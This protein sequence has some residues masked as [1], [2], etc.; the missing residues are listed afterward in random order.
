MRRIKAWMIVVWS[1]L[2]ASGIALGLIGSLTKLPTGLFWG[3]ASI[4]WAGVITWLLIALLTGKKKKKNGRSVMVGNQSFNRIMRETE[5]A[6]ARYTDAVNRRGILK[7]SALYERPWFLLCGSTK[8]GK[9][10][11]LNGSGL[12][13]PLRYP[14]E[15][16]GLLVEG[17]N[18][19]MWYFA[20]EAVWID[21]P[22]EL[23][24]ESGR[25]DWQ[26]LIGA[27]QRVRPGNPAD[28]VAMVVNTNEVLNTDDQGIKELAKKLRSRIDELISLWGIEFPVYLLFNRTDEVPGFNEYFADQIDRGNEQIF[29]ATLPAKMLSVMPRMA[30][31]EEFNLLCKSLTDLRLD[32]L[33]KER[34]EARKRMICRFV[35]HFEGI[36]Q[37]LGALV[38]ELFKP[39]N[40]EGKP[41]FRGFYFTS[42]T[43][44]KAG[45]GSETAAPA[46]SDMSMTLIN[47]P[48]NPNRAFAP[49]AKK[50]PTSVGGSSKKTVR[51][52]FVLPLFREIMVKDKT[53]VTSTQ[54]RTRREMIRHYT[55]IGSIVG[56]ALLL[57][58]LVGH[59]YLRTARFM[60]EVSATLKR[61]PTEDA[62]LMEQYKAL[63]I[64]HS[65]MEKLQRYEDRG[66]PLTMGVGFYRG[67]TVLQELKKSYFYRLRR[68]M[69]VPAVKYLEY[70]LR[71]RTSAF[72][73]LAG[74]DY[75]NLYRSLKAYLSI[76]EGGPREARDLDTTFMREMLLNAI[77]QSIVATVKNN[78]LP[79]QVE[80]IL[81]D[82][83][84]LYLSYLCRKEYP[85]I[86]ENQ[87]LVESARKR[88]SRLPSAGALYDAVI[89]RLSTEA[90]SFTL[91]DILKRDGEGILLS[92]ATI[93]ALFTQEGWENYISDAINEAARNPFKVDWVIGVAQDALPQSAFDSKGLREDMVAAYLTDFKS[94]WLEFLGSVSVAP[95]G[96]LQR[97]SRLIGKLAGDG[98]EITTLLE[99]VAEY[100][101]LRQESEAEAAGSK[102]LEAASKFKKTKKNANKLKKLKSKTGFTLPG[103]SPFDTHNAFFDHLRS[104][105]RSSGSALGGFEGYKDKAM[106]LA[107]KCGTIDAQGESKAITIFNGKDDDPLLSGWNFTQKT[108]NSMPEEL[109][110][111]LRNILLQP[112]E[113]TGNAA[114]IVLTRTLNQKWQEEIIKP[115]TSRFSGRYPFSSRG[116]EASFND[117]MDFFR[118]VNG[119]FWGFYERVLS[120]FI[121]KDGNR[122]MV[123]QLGSLKLQFNPKLSQSL[124]TA[125]RVRDIF[126]K[127][128]GTQ[129]ALDITIIPSAGNKN[130]ARLIIGTQDLELKPGG[131]SVHLKWPLE[132]NAGTTL[133]VIVSSNFSQEITKSGAWGFMKL[134]EMARC[135]KM[136]KSSFSAK[137]QVN[138]QNQY[139]VFIEA[140]VQVAGSDHPFSDKIFQTFDCPTDLLLKPVEDLSGN[141]V[142]TSL[143]GD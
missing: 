26:A 115:F 58:G 21:T 138:V 105:I 55:I 86:Q 143:E 16:D 72:G 13:F 5:E 95:F 118:P 24:E 110:A 140:R 90:P 77:K 79:A 81:Q 41:L 92:S 121:I 14:S 128:D 49:A 29:G 57:S 37:K 123:R 12:N 34:V 85:R 99:T 43:E 84:G 101:T 53:L 45:G 11:L 87:R 113:Y 39:S 127:Q 33:H 119:T 63:D 139:M 103:S 56:A 51:S 142:K 76:S 122:W 130:T 25:D 88:L 71:S 70:D 27:M 48:L 106:T 2:F 23:M 54:K 136:N 96:D 59:T 135:N 60:N 28:G 137:W 50:P 20:N 18:Q 19:I 65:L 78:R 94:K 62:P 7:K 126:F 17:A 117:V 46:S 67:K 74:E 100:S 31:I 10:S 52:A 111:S 133:K 125:E 104:F 109:A 9:S 42:C 73:E 82:N 129:R 40:Y 75:D 44:L 66:T 68:F 93:S 91:D 83:M 131:K 6:V 32:K 1:V 120:S 36:Q 107:E 69:V 80:T 22:G 134:L 108:L 102:A 141:D 15:K 98:S 4:V 61:L 38:A 35:I 47:H 132:M 97:A 8:S 114:T 112:F 116:E 124:S 3:I 89:N 30:F 64:V